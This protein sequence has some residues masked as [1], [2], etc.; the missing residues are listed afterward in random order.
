MYQIRLIFLSIYLA[1]LWAACQDEGPSESGPEDDLPE[2]EIPEGQSDQLR[3]VFDPLLDIYIQ[4]MEGMI[5]GEVEHVQMM[6]REMMEM[7]GNLVREMEDSGHKGVPVGE[8]H[9]K[10]TGIYESGNK[11]EIDGKFNDFSRNLYRLL[12]SVEDTQDRE[13]FL[14]YCDKAL[15]GK[16]GYWIALSTTETNPY[17]PDDEDCAEVSDKIN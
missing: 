6:A 4:M 13:I 16:G 5:T 1:F 12:K 15:D 8:I 3:G 17:L 2:I 9:Q 7:S 11:G 10:A 14:M